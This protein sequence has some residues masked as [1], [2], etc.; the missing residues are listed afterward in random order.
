MLMELSPVNQ[1]QFDMFDRQDGDKQLSA[2][3]ALDSVN[4]RWGAGTL[5]YAGAGTKNPGR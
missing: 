5:F 4:N 3:S 2:M 1:P